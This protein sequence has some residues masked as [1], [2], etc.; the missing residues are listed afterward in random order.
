[1]DFTLCLTHACNLRCDYCYAG[2]KTN[3]R[4]TWE[5]AKQAVDFAF[6]HTLRHSRRSGDPPASQLGY[7]GGEPL[8]EWELLKRSAGY[9]MDRAVLDGIALKKTVTTNMTLLDDEKVAWFREH[10]F[11]LGLSLDGNA[12]MH[13]TLR[14]SASG[15]GSHEAA[16]PALRHFRGP[17][18]D[19]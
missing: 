7:F 13:D 6:D 16:A 10:G 11:Y 17:R 15:R 19:G 9:A 1:M 5:V 3:R 14:R 18:P 8:L 2:L 4:M 12:A